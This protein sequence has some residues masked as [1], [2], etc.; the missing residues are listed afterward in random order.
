M[1]RLPSLLSRT[2][3]SFHSV[4][5][6][7]GNRQGHKTSTYKVRIGPALFLALGV[8]LIALP[9]AGKPANRIP[10]LE[11][12]LNYENSLLRKFRESPGLNPADKFGSDPFKIRYLPNRKQYL[13]LLRNRSEILLA[14]RSLNLMDRRET[15]RSPTAWTLVNNRFLFVSGNQSP[16]IQLYEI[17]PHKILSRGKIRLRGVASV[18]DLVYVPSLHSLFL[19]DDFDRR[20]H[21]LTLAPNWPGQNRLTFHQKAFPLPAGPVQIR[22]QNN[23]LLINLLLDHTLL[24]VPLTQGQPDFSLS[25]QITHDG[26]IW[27]FDAIASDSAMMIAAGGV[28][29][30]PLNRLGEEFGYV[31]SFLFLYVL[32]RDR[33]TGVYRWRPTDREVPGRY[34]QQNLSEINIVTPKALRF[35]SASHDTSRL[36]VSAFGSPKLARFDVR[37]GR[38][39]LTGQFNLP[40]GTTDFVI[41]QEEQN[42]K[43][44][45]K[46]DHSLVITNAL[47]DQIY[48]LK[49]DSESSAYQ[50]VQGIPLSKAKL[51]RESRIGE[52]LFFT[53]LLTPH[54]R[55]DGEL[56]RFT[57]EACHHEGTFDGRVHYTGRGHVFASTKTVRNLANNVPLFSR[58]GDKSLASMVLAEFRVANQGRKDSFSV[59][60]SA[61]PWLKEIGNL[62]SELSPTYLRRA[63][64]S[65]FVD[66][67]HRPNPWQTQSRKLSPKAL[68]GLPVFRERCEYCHQA[69]ISTREYESL[70]Y[71][72][73]KIWLE[74]EEKDLVWGAPF[75][76]KTGIKPYVHRA[77]ARVPSLRRVKQK[78]PYFTDGSSRTL[79]DLLSRFRYQDT[80]AWHHYKPRSGEAKP[81]DVK[82]LTAEEIESLEEL[83]RFF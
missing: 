78:Y 17:T 54:N 2:S 50:R 76:T 27:A 6:P 39:Q 41:V 66:F 24:I 62:P 57:C 14:D 35:E 3:P 56:S 21:Q 63:F 59:E 25:S 53:T 67:Q 15:P 51:S 34:A 75:Y 30:H 23:H 48:R 32:R 19:L 20:L 29:N 5:P 52:L 71:T 49:I 58:A 7:R 4:A 79:R 61:F 9:A 38:L 72:D 55:T 8:I 22:Y 83:L 36:W 26:P 44:P 28:E 68:K 31:D 60:L 11:G 40:P 18:R 80:T 10:S 77:G 12:L 1:G 74:A 70:P 45:G 43:K 81:Q 33:S 65:F 16:E 42:E 69:T 13:I 46:E 37:E 73:W 47:F 82:A 64:L